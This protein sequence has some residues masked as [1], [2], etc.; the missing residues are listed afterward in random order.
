MLCNPPTLGPTIE[1]EEQAKNWIIEIV[2]EVEAIRHECDVIMVTNGAVAMARTTFIKW[3]I[4]RGEA[5]GV[6]QA[7]K[8]FNK[9]SD[10]AYTELRARVLATQVPT[11]VAHP[12]LLPFGER[13]QAHDQKTDYMGRWNYWLRKKFLGQ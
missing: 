10:T 3:M 4:K 6:L 1:T 8:R 11:I 2:N 9:I 7:S 5:L 12:D 13:K